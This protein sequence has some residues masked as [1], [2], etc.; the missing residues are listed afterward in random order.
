[1]RIFL[2]NFMKLKIN[3]LTALVL[4]GAALSVPETSWAYI[5]PGAGFA[6]VS[7]F[8]FI[9]GALAMAFV[10]ILTLPFRSLLRLARKKKRRGKAKVDRVV[11]LGLDGLDPVLAGEFMDRGLLPHLARLRAEGFFSPLATTNPPIS[12]VAWSSFM[13]GTN[14]GKH[15]IFDFLR[16]DPR[17]YLPSLS[18]AEIG[19]GG[20][21]GKPLVK[22]LRKGV[23]FWKIL[24]EHGIFSIVLK[25]PITF[26]PEPFANGMLL[27]GLC[28]P[29]LKGSQGTFTYFTTAAADRNLTQGYLVPLSGPG[30]VYT[31]GIPGPAD[32]RK[33]RGELSA[34]LTLTVEGPD[35]VVAEVGG[36]R[37]VLKKGRLSPWIEISF[38]AGR[39]SIR[40]IAQFFLKQAEG[41]LHLYLSPVQIDPGRPAMPVSHP[42]IYSIMLSKIHGPF[43]TLGLPQDTWALNEGVLTDDGFLQQTYGCHRTLEDIFFSS[44][45]QVKKGLVCCVFDTTDVVQHEFWRYL[46]DDHPALAGSAEPPRPE[47]IEE[48]YKNMDA[49][50]GRLAGRLR[51][52]DLLV[53]CSDHGF[54]LFRRGVNINTWLRDN[55][56]LALKEGKRTGGEWF[57]DVDWSKTRAY[58]FGLSGL[59]LNRAGRESSGTV[60]PEEVE[61]LKREL[62][63]KLSGLADPETGQEAVTTL[64]DTAA[65]YSGPFKGNAPD[66][67]LGFRPGFRHSWESVSGKVEETVFI[68]NDKAWSADHCIDHRFVPGVF[69]CD[70]PVDCA[71]PSITDIAPTVLDLFGIEPPPN[72]DGRVLDVAVNRE[73]GT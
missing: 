4:G 2:I 47:V 12:P 24:G 8:I 27:A 71:S 10:L 39:S 23:P 57:A 67:I 61:P 14:P 26:P 5:G 9:L 33:D 55:G 42:L 66:L 1:M 41:D 6:F 56:Y 34:P 64:Y 72:M 69:F 35:T 51:E 25:V 17:T 36:K 63:E 70:R 54:K 52:K 28:T 7:S 38:K 30:P 29:D 53:I 65:V 22:M 48:L 11:I 19:S 18:S 16:R 37:H 68:D 50:V 44:L 59:Y 13:T 58:A 73:A 32:P 60:A 3:I 46:E 49:M 20:A 62:I 43:A 31:T 21:K 40:G 45:R 15:N